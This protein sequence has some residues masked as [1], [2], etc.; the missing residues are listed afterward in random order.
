M[1]FKIKFYFSIA[2]IFAVLLIAHTIPAMA[3]RTTVEG[4]LENGAIISD[5]KMSD[6]SIWAYVNVEALIDVSPSTVWKTLIDMENWPAWLPMN[7]RTSFVSDEA[8]ALITHD[9]AKDRTKV[10]EIDGEHPRQ[11]DEKTYSGKW[12][13]TV[14]EEYD[15]VWPLKDEWVIRR[16]DF[17]ETSDPLRA[18]WR[19]VASD[20]EEEDGHWEIGQWKN[21][22]KSLLKYYYRVK[23]KKG[24]PRPIFNTAV[25]FTVNS[26][27]KSLRREV[28]KHVNR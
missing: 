24:V 21:G 28:K 8:E 5:V 13:R 27:I 9:V 17:D 11:V 6:G 22:K 4:R 16:Y 19:K 20:D 25:T 10:Y 2:I 14:I 26:M 18:S 15:L 7:R 12:H 23:I 3:S 1:N